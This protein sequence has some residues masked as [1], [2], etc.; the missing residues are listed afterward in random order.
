MKDTLSA[1]TLRYRI[2]SEDKKARGRQSPDCLYIYPCDAGI[3]FFN[4]ELCIRT[5]AHSF[6]SFFLYSEIV[7]IPMNALLVLGARAIYL[8]AVQGEISWGILL[9]TVAAGVFILLGYFGK[10]AINISESTPG[11]P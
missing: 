11:P 7:F 8:A 1:K 4:N 9:P 10:R 3:P 2:V 6:W 5:D